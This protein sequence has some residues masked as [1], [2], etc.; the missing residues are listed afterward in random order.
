[1]ITL[2]IFEVLFFFYLLYCIFFL[3]APGRPK[4]KLEPR[5]TSN[6]LN[7]VAETSQSISIFGGARPR[8][9]K[10]KLELAKD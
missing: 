4:L 6:P 3:D 10:H 5:K 7:Q 2:Q 1:M 8:E 9:E